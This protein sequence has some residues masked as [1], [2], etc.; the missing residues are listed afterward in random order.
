MV[1]AYDIPADELIIH[2][3]ENLKKDKKIEAPQWSQFVKTGCH[4][5]KIPQNRDWWYIR[6]ASLL[7]KVYINGPIGISDLRSEYGGK[8]QVGYN[9]AHHKKSGGAI[10]RK[11]LQQL[12]VA[13]YITKKSKGRT[14]S[15]EG[16]KKV[17]RMATDIYKDL[18]NSRPELG[19]YG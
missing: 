14:I 13:G 10:V 16:T 8:K 3:A 12:E 17:D 4:A 7:R 5:E 11:A 9:I 19:R 18:V 6:C 2:L 1:K 15:D